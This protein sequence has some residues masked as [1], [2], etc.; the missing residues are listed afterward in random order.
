M[1]HTEADKRDQIWTTKNTLVS[2]VK[3][4]RV[5]WARGGVPLLAG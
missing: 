4:Y 3:P 5:I 2:S 1:A